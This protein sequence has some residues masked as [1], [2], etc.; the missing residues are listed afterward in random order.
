MNLPYDTFPEAYVKSCVFVA[1][2]GNP[3][4]R[5]EARLLIFPKREV[6][7]VISGSDSRWV[8]V[9]TSRWERLDPDRK[10]WFTFLTPDEL[11]VIERCVENSSAIREL[12]EVTRGVTP[13]KETKSERRSYPGLEGEVHRYDV[14]GTTELRFEYHEGLA[15][16]KPIEAFC[17]PRL[18][19]REMI[20]RQFRLQASYAEQSFLVNKSHQI[21]RP[22]PNVNPKALLGCL[23][24]AALAFYHVNISAIA[25]RDDFPKI[26]MDET[27]RLPVPRLLGSDHPDN[28][29]LAESVESVLIALGR[30][31]TETIH[32]RNAL[33]SALALEDSQHLTGTTQLDDLD[34]LGWDGRFPNWQPDERSAEAGRW[35]PNGV[36]P[37]LEG[38]GPG[39]IAWDLISRVYPSYPLPGIDAEAWELAAWND[40]CEVLRKNKTKI[41][42]PRVRADLTGSGAILHPTGALRQLRET[43][44]EHHARIRANRAR[45][46]ELDFLIDRIVFRL[47]DLTLDE[48][49]LILSRVGPGRPL[50]PAAAGSGRSPSKAAMEARG[51]LMWIEG[52]PCSV[53]L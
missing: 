2:V 22:S 43:F 20:S 1:D 3:G 14:R 31:R 45:A 42:N 18:L 25:Q 49:R 10:P 36:S 4:E 37:P 33:T 40:L 8:V 15:E 53:E 24:S 28:R 5:R 21:I 47:F 6:V 39:E 30:S 23:D 17:G 16:Y 32:F 52:L 29:E 34:Y 41:G 35:Y 46:A 51:C 44:L 7:T 13:Y 27:R 26:V 12:A 19:M 48:Q 50:P 38:A 11:T 9:D